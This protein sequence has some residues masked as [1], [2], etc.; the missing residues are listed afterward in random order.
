MA[1]TARNAEAN[2]AISGTDGT[3]VVE[4]L[5]SLIRQETGKPVPPNEHPS[6]REG[7]WLLLLSLNV[8]LVVLRLPRELLSDPG[9]ELAGK[10]LPVLLGSLFVIYLAWFRERMLALTR[11]S[12]FNQSQ[13]ALFFVLAFISLPLFPITPKV[14]P[15]GTA[16]SVDGKLHKVVQRIGLACGNAHDV[17][18]YPPKDSEAKQRQ[19]RFPVRSL[20][21]AVWSRGNGPE[22]SLLYPVDFTARNARSKVQVRKIQGELYDDIF[23]GSDLDRLDRSAFV[24][25]MNGNRVRTIELPLGSYELQWILESGQSCSAYPLEVTA[26]EQAEARLE[27]K[28]CPG[29]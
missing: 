24:L 10:L 17:I 3:Q 16:F 6:L 8:V 21:G 29:R 4:A 2:D 12:R 13:V 25:G 15:K 27:D 5:R 18:L 11:H 22:W 14:M 19:F 23:E 7:L 1:A 20:L 9:V 28:P 26:G